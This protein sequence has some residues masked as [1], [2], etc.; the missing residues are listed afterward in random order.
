MKQNLAL[1]CSA[2][3]CAAVYTDCVCNESAFPLKGLEEKLQTGSYAETVYSDTNAQTALRRR[4]FRTLLEKAGNPDQTARRG[5]KD[6]D[7]MIRRHALAVYLEKNGEKG[8]AALKD[9][10]TEKDPSAA[11]YVLWCARRIRT[12]ELKMEIFRL[13][14][15]KSPVPEIRQKAKRLASFDF[16]RRNVRLQDDPTWDHEVSVIRKLPLPEHSWRF[17]LDPWEDGHERGYWKR[18]FDDSNWNTISIG[19]NWEKQGYPG[20]DGI[21]YYRGRFNAPPKGE[22]NAAELFFEAVDEGAWVWVNGKY[23]GQHDMGRNGWNKPFYL[24]ITK[25]IVWGGE[26]VLTVRVEDTLASGGI[27]KKVFLHILK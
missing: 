16:F 17:R 11:Q 5:M 4:A 19:K 18:D 24:D 23:V 25:E 3:L 20:Y 26:N 9:F 13:L 15:A 14:S 8:A 10:A 2:L 6:P 7:P 1:R 21:A 27:W 12:K 22:A